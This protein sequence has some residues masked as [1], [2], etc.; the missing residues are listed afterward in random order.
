MNEV[1]WQL[2]RNIRP[3][4]LVSQGSLFLPFMWWLLGL[5]HPP[6]DLDSGFISTCAWLLADLI[7]LTHMD[8]CSL[9]GIVPQPVLSLLCSSRPRPSLAELW[10]PSCG[11]C[12][13]SAKQPAF[14]YQKWLSLSP[15]SFLLTLP[16]GGQQH[17]AAAHG[18][19]SIWALVHFSHAAQDNL[20][21]PAM[22]AALQPLP[23]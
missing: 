18:P 16:P 5:L 15:V 22:T 9:V 8:S 19:C 11:P 3:E 6:V 4:S 14:S 21:H 1:A 10:L 13:R 12:P 17:T 23:L 20:P 2:R 7:L